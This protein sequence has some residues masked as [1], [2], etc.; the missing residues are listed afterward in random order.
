MSPVSSRQV[1]LPDFRIQ[2]FVLLR[3][4][5]C[6]AE[7]RVCTAAMLLFHILQKHYPK[8]FYDPYIMSGF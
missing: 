6:T 3:A 5:C 8:Y 4:T 2:F 7:E 1:S